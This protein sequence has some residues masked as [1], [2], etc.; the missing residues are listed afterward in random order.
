MKRSTSGESRLVWKKAASIRPAAYL[1]RRPL[2]TMF[3]VTFTGYFVP[4]VAEI[5]PFDGSARS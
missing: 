5:V 3:L 1:P 2:S 4:Q